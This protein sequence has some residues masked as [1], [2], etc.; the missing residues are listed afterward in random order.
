MNCSVFHSHVCSPRQL[1]YLQSKDICLTPKHHEHDDSFSVPTPACDFVINSLFAESY[2][3]LYTMCSVSCAD[4]DR[5]YWERVLYLNAHTDVKLLTYLDVDRDLWPIDIEDVSDLDAPMI[6][7]TARKKF[8]KSA[9]H[10]MQ[11]LSCEYNPTAKLAILAETF[12]EIS[13]CVSRFALAGSEHVWSSDDLLPAFMYVVVRA[14]IQHLG[15]E[16][17]LIEDFS[18]H[19][20]GAGQIELMFT[21][22]KASFVHICNEKSLP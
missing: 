2:A 16:I 7:A 8:Y 6:R 17:R 19:L 22:L 3:V 18:P 1:S 13:T 9:I 4:M 12:S 21:M 11:R 15:A 20:R 5:K 14:Q 10:T